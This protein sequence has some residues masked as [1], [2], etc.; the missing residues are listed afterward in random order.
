MGQ[1]VKDWSLAMQMQTGAVILTLEGLQLVTFYKIFG[2]IIGWKSKQQSTVA[3]AT[4]E[5]E[6]M[7]SADCARQAI[8]L[9]IWLTGAGFK[10]DK[11]LPIVN[12][13]AGAIALSKN[14]VHH[15]RSKHIA[16]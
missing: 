14:L 10:E 7:S 13:N 16:M 6:Y 2:G 8:W 4:T 12:G 15:D 9:N 11:T 1:A 5:A 3:L